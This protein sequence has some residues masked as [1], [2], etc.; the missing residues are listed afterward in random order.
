MVGGMVD[1]E[2]DCELGWGKQGEGWE[3]STRYGAD[4]DR[5]V[6]KRRWDAFKRVPRAVGPP[7]DELWVRSFNNRRGTAERGGQG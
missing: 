2:D 1:G 3:L 7:S 6:A 4:W 5:D